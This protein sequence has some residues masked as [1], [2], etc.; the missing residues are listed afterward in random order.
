VQAPARSI[1]L[2]RL[3]LFGFISARGLLWRAGT[4]LHLEPRMSGLNACLTLVAVLASS[5]ALAAEQTAMFIARSLNLEPA[6]AE[7]IGAVCSAQYAKV[8]QGSVLTPAQAQ[9]AVGPNGSLTEAAVALNAKELVELTLVNL[10]TSASRGRLLMNAVLRSADGAELYR[11][12]V[13]ADSVD[14]TVP[15]CERLALALVNKTPVETTRNRH[16]VT[17]AEARATRNPNRVGSERVLGVKA[18][19]ASAFASEQVNPLGGLSFNARLEQERYFIELGVGFAVPAVTNLSA[20][21]YGGLTTELGASYYLTDGDI[22]PYIGGG[23]QPR[24]FFSGSVLNLAPYAQ[25]GLMLWRQSSTRLYV[26]AR[27]SQNVLPVARNYSLGGTSTNL[28]PTEVGVQIGV[29]W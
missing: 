24:I 23:V 21:S 9:A 28:Y 5:T 17:A 29:G 13:T 12:D 4:T 25:V 2:N 20:A 3:N 22:A 8:S 14:D 19:F 11:A 18:T 16:N 7:T 15:A 6:Q 1:F 10:T 27:V 26:D